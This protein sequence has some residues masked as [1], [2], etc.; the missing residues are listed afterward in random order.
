[1]KS[2]LFQMIMGAIAIVAFFSLFFL[3]LSDW[4]TL[5]EVWKDSLFWILNV[6]VIILWG[7]VT[8]NKFGD[9]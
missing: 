2:K 4:E 3:S 5:K 1:M 9:D 8:Y 6:I 7:V